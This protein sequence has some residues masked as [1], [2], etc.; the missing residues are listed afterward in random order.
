MKKVFLDELPR[1]EKEGKGKKGTINW[2]ASIGYK[3]K[4]IYDDIQGEIEIIDSINDYLYVKYLTNK[5]YRID[6]YSFKEC[7]I[8]ILIGKIT[9]EFKF[10]I[11][12]L[13][14][15][16]HRDIIIIE[17]EYRTKIN[18]NHKFCEKWYKYKCNKCGWNEGWIIEGHL[19]EGN[20]CNVCCQNPRIVVEEINSIVA[21]E[22]TQ[23]MIP[24][25]QG[26][27]N[28]AK[29]YTPRN[30]HTVYFKCPNCGRVKDKPMR[31]DDLYK[32]HSIGCLCSDGIS[33]P[34]KIMFNVLEQLKLHFIY[35][36]SKKDMKWCNGFI[37]DFYFRINNKEYMIETHGK[38]HY[39]QSNR[40]RSLEE[41]QENDKLKEQLANNN[42]IENYIV[43]DCRESDLEWIKNNIL[44]S[45]LNELFDLSNID[46]VK[47]QE[48]A[49]GS[50]IKKVCNLKQDN[51]NI[52]IC[53]IMK[54]I[55]LS[56]TTIRK[57]LTIGTKLG[58][59]NYNPKEEMK[60]N[61]S[62]N[63][64]N[65]NKQVEIFKDNKSL[66]IFSSCAELE[67]QSE[68]LFNVKL[69]RGKISAVCTNK[70]KTHKGFTFKFV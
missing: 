64:K 9:K 21:K 16:N 30:T 44:Q 12:Q 32:T 5:I 35:Q 18:N 24:Y 65:N 26:G 34:E 2:K 8:G 69:N 11:G 66:G 38:Q 51:P 25:F 70:R 39:K 54:L 57:Y 60:K 3:V 28:E 19:I 58:W 68:K 46:W 48:F 10:R 61:G 56:N 7:R 1:W 59:C 50:L 63:G 4:F 6:T 27:Y 53:E 62:K 14:K 31:I 47:C 15:D 23:W 40:G 37:Y 13:V 22:E 55:K 36:F 42:D 52:T 20:G 41:E 45:K 17:R 67:K 49:L 29:L 43:I 33:Y